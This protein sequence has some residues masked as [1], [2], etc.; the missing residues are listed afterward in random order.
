MEPKTQP[1][2][3]Q[4]GGRVSIDVEIRREFDLEEGDYVMI[5]VRPMEEANE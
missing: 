1:A 3:M 5:T 4:H 2:K